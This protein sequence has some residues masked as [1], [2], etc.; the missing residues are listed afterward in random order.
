MYKIIFSDIDGTLLT[1]DQRISVNTKKKIKELE[2]KGIRFVLASSRPE[3]AVFPIMRE[4]DIKAPVISY[5]GALVH[6]ADGN[7]IQSLEIPPQTAQEIHDFITDTYTGICCCVYSR[8]LWLADDKKNEWLIKEEEIT[9]LSAVVGKIADYPE[10]GGVHKVL[11][12]GDKAVIDDIAAGLGQRFP[13][14]SIC[15]SKD[16]YLEINNPA[17][18]KANAMRFLCDF[19]NIPLSQ[20][21]ALGDGEVDME[22][23]QTAGIGF[24]MENAPESMKNTAENIAESNDNE[25]VLKALIQIGL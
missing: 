23:I 7:I 22:M 24:V 25:G 19:M 21:T 5:S 15:R 20:T 12:M 8:D 6:D 2:K 9:G 1:S 4:L 16:T 18:S 3:H 14:V 17:A 11:C 10:Y 13:E